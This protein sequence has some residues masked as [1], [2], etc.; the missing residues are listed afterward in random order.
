MKEII[1]LGNYNESEHEASRIVSG[2]GISPTIKENYG[3]IVAVLVNE[4][5][6]KDKTSNKARIHTL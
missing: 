4:K 2:W 6:S 5:A 1:V 3:T